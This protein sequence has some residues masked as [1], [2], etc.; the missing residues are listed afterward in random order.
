M[1]AVDELRILHNIL[2]RGGDIGEIDLHVELAKAMSAING[3]KAQTDMQ[4]MA[5]MPVPPTP[6]TAGQTI[7]PPVDNS[8]TQPPQGLNPTENQ[9]LV[10]PTQNV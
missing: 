8:A 9:P 2:A 7:S 5:N 4:N 6:A 10:P 1:S 3:M